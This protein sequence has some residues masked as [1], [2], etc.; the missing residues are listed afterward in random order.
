MDRS[1]AL[2]VSKNA[3]K[4]K[5]DYDC[6]VG[7]RSDVLNVSNKKS[8]ESSF[9]DLSHSS[10]IYSL[11]KHSNHRCSHNRSRDF[12]I[13]SY[14]SNRKALRGKFWIVLTHYMYVRTPT[15]QKSILMRIRLQKRHP[16]C[17]QQKLFRIKF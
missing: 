14:L 2:H 17:L 16:I 11:E 8:S 4:S 12:V 13:P 5:V 7:C 15:S 6:N 1:N 9:E 3:N 10:N